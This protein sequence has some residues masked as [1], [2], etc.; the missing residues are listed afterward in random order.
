VR[1]EKIEKGTH[2]IGVNYFAAG[3]MGVSRG[4]V[5]VMRGDD[6]EVNRPAH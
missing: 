4:I 5:V 2:H 1:A 6:L 3:P